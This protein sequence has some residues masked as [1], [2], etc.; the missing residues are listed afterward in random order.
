MGQ[1]TQAGRCELRRLES[2][3]RRAPSCTRV[4]QCASPHSASAAISPRHQRLALAP[5]L[6]ISLASLVSCSSPPP[7]SLFTFSTRQAMSAPLSI[8]FYVPPPTPTP[9][10]P[11]RPSFLNAPVQPGVDLLPL[12]SA[13]G[14]DAEAQHEAQAALANAGCEAMEV[15]EVVKRIEEKTQMACFRAMLLEVRPPLL[16][17]LMCR[18]AD[19]RRSHSNRTAP[20]SSCNSRAA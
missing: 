12:L 18:A 1:Q 13:A 11:R 2:K 17:C 7:P 14:S 19:P 10:P 16:F 9:L 4:A 15:A 8:S 3:R 5:P 6:A 20:R